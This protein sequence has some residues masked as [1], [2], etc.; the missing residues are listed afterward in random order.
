MYPPSNGG[1][2]RI[3]SGLSAGFI[4]IAALGTASEE[5]FARWYDRPNSGRCP[6]TLRI[7]ANLNQCKAYRVPSKPAEL[8]ELKQRK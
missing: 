8:K 4:I 5:A 3:I 6:K 1:K 7:V 2:M